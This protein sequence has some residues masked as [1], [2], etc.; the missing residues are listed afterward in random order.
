[1]DKKR[2]ND[3]TYFRY[4]KRVKNWIK[5]LS[6][7]INREGEHIR[8]PK[9]ADVLKDNGQCKLRNTSTLCSC[10]DCSGYYKYRRNEKKLEDRRL[11]RE[12]YEE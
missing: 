9:V 7:Y 2:R 10:Y 1:M 8:N 6:V 4:K 12:F 11:L 5:N 3:L